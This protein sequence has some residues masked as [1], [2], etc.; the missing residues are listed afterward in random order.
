M[1]DDGDGALQS[2]RNV[3]R[4]F[5][6]PGLVFFPHTILPL[7]IFEPRYRQLTEDALAEGDR[8]ITMVQERAD[9]PSSL[10]GVPAIEEVACL[11]R[12]FQHQRLPDGRFNLLLLGLKRV[13]LTRELA[14]EKLYRVAEAEAMEDQ[15]LGPPEGDHRRNDLD[16]LFREVVT[17]LGS[18]PKEADLKAILETSLP[19]GP[20]TDLIGYTLGLPAEEKQRLL[21]EA[22]VT[23]RADALL[24]ILGRILASLPQS[25]PA[26]TFPP[27][28]SAN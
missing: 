21:A 20:L 2:F 19:L 9:A 15:E 6:L 8:L 13:R 10:G 24:E 28:F 25:H 3:C 5:P 17:R 27:P 16:H 14:T 1:A 7:H 4:L 12:I 11:G 22:R 18:G 26:P 23:H